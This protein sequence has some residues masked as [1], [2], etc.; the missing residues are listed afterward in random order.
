MKHFPMMPIFSSIPFAPY[1]AEPA[2]SNRKP[3]ALHAIKI[4]LLVLSPITYKPILNA[5]NN[6][7]LATIK[8]N[9]IK[10]V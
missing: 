8:I 9:P 3:N 4:Q 6:V 7:G 1:H 5:Y 2:L 10:Y